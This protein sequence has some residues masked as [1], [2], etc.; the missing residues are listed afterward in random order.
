LYIY[1]CQKLAIPLHR[2]HNSR[3]ALII[4]TVNASYFAQLTTKLRYASIPPIL[5]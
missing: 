5:Y 2:V 1:L 3:L 4:A